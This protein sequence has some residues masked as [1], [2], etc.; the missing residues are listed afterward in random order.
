MLLYHM[1]LMLGGYLY[2]ERMEK[3]KAQPRRQRPDD[4]WPTVSVLIPAHN[5]DIVIRYTL[6][7]MLRLDYPRDKIEIIV[8][9][10][11][12]HDATGEIVD[13]YCARDSRVRCLHLKPPHAAK[14]KSNALNQGL[15]IAK[16]EFIVV[17][18]ADNTPNSAAVKY[19]VE[20]ALEDP[21]IGAVTG[22]FR[23]INAKKNL[24]TRFINIETISFQWMA[25]AGRWYWFGISTIPGTNF[26]IRKSLLEEM[27]GWDVKALTEDTEMSIRL[28]E[29]GY[30]IRF[31][32]LAITWEQEPETWKVWFKQR[33]RWVRG[34]QY[35]IVKN[36]PRI[37][38]RKQ[39]RIVFD[40]V[41][42]FFTYFVFLGGVVLSHLMMLLNLLGIVNITLPGPFLLI[43]LLAYILFIVEIMVAL[44]IEKTELTTRNFFTLSLMYVTYSQ[45]WLYLIFRSTW[46]QLRAAIIREEWKWDKT[47]RFQ[48]PAAQK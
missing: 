28:Y 2:A 33:T 43:W 9:D 5:E 14:G 35:V 40:L 13:E 45:L 11:N 44:A 32:P 42:F 34:N 48:P 6:D 12:S 36:L 16:G 21:T 38:R 26:L 30:K 41:Y 8:I 24:L 29:K 18:D 27:G 3:L 1:F 31:F 39:G 47:Q 7:A 4:E 19:L 22:K 20:A 23:V 37:L 17:Y 10:D 15:R 46:L 25:Q